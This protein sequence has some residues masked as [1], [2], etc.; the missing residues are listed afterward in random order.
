MNDKQAVVRGETETQT[1]LPRVDV[2]EDENGIQLFA[3]FPGVPKDHLVVNVE[4]DTLVLEGEIMPQ[5]SEQ[6]EAVYAEVQLSRFRRAF[7]LSSELDTT[8]IDAELRDGVLNVR[9]PK[10]A[11]AQ[12]RKIV[13][14]SA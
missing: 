11:H 12:P 2:F 8:R 14:K 7:T 3:D 13:V 10:H 9:V 4:G 5:L 6:L 1:L